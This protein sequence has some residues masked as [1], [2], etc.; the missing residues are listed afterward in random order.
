MS[1]VMEEKQGWIPHVFWWQCPEEM[2]RPQ[3]DGV[4]TKGGGCLAEVGGDS[5]SKSQTIIP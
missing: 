2:E 5:S 4:V 3:R 1:L